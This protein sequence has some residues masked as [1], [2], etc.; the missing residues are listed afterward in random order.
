L[1]KKEAVIEMMKDQPEI[2]DQLC[3]EFWGDWEREFD[4]LD[5]D[6]QREYGYYDSQ[7]EK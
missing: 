3:K 4:N 1:T 6:E 2:I 7:E 5:I